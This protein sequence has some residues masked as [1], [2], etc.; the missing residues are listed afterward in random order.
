MINDHTLARFEPLADGLLKPIYDGYSFANLAATFHYLLTGERSGDLLPVDCFG[1]SYPRPQKIV[2]FFIDSFGWQFWQRHASQSRIMRRVI[3]DGVLTPISALFPSTT[4]ASVSTLNLG[5]LPAR[6]AVYEWNMYVPDFGETIQSLAFATLGVRSVP[7]VAKG[8]DVRE[9][10]IEHETMHQR[11]ARRGMRSIQLSHRNYAH[12]PYNG[13]ASA[14]AEV[15]VHTTLPEALV[16]LKS[17]MA[18]TPGKALI[19]F[20][21]AGLDTSAHTYGP[22]SP[23]HEAEIASFWLTMDALLADAISED[24]LFLFTADHGHVGSKSGDT[25][26]INERWPQIQSWLSTSHTGQTI[27]PNGS[28]RDMFLHVK[29]E[30]HADLIKLLRQGLDG[31]ATV[32]TVDEALANG[33]FGLEPVGGELRRRLGDVLV[34]PRLGYFVWWREPEIMSNPL[35]GHHG[36]LSPEELITV[37]G[38]VDSVADR[39]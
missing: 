16:Q 38:V 30:R 26:Y 17:V 10:V 13:I 35:R 28:P 20:Y 22:G 27:W 29:P 33:L 32:M 34:L 31:I 8:F 23:E 19:N 5:C 3:R 2:L 18:T 1:G 25:L 24:T 7:C 39:L 4:A 11:L 37:L 21:W 36:G 12:S 9:M 6:H 14:G 15:I